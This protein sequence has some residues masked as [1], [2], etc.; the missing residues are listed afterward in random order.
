MDS[1]IWIVS[2]ALAATGIAIRILLP[3]LL[4][5]RGV[6]FFWHTRFGPALVFDS[7]DQ[8]GT[9]V[10][11]LNV[12]G[13]FQS[14]CY[15]DE[16]LLWLPVCEYHIRWAD[17]TESHLPTRAQA[18]PYE[19]LVLG[20]GGF[21]FPKWLVYARPDITCEVAEVDPKIV[22]I[23]YDHFFLD[24]LEEE[25]GRERIRVRC[26]DAFRILR[27]EERRRD[28]IVNDVF[29]KDRPLG[30]L[31]TDEGARL[32]R[33]RLK[34]G[35]LYI[36]NV[37]CRLKGRGRRVLSDTEE[38]FSRVF[39]HVDVILERPQEPHLIGNNCLLAWMDSE[40]EG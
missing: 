25:F 2:C 12:G 24:R 40:R 9:S 17:A 16:D 36:S 14:V 13:T 5:L 35:G 33:D 20:G 8:D 19:A 23:A 27:C 26:E 39:D 11:L 4:A 38:A 31:A 15:V 3:R 28:L 6:Q 7:T 21:S 37:R 10:R 18:E 29:M 30:P 32:I 34:P 1:K 22:E